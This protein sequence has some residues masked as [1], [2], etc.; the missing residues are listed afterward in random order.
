MSVLPGCAHTCDL[1]ADLVAENARLRGITER[2][3]RVG[4]G[5][6]TADE[7]QHVCRGCAA[8]YTSRHAA[9]EC[10]DLDYGTTD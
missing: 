4:L 6:V 1:V 7:G 9:A 2:A 8:V 3:A 10:A 5:L